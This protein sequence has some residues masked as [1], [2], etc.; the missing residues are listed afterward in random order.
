MPKFRLA[1]ETASFAGA[2]PEPVRALVDFPPLLVNTATLVKLAA[3]VGAKLTATR[4][5]WPGGRLKGLPLWMA[6]GRVVA[7]APV[8]VWPPKLMTWKVWVVLWPTT[9]APKLR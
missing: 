5:V 6:K 9:K 7:T 2:S 4:P 8:S 3:L 1:G